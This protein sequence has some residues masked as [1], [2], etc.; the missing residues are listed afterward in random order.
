F[1]LAALAST[2]IHAGAALFAAFAK[3]GR[4]GLTVTLFLIGT[5]ISKATLRKVGVRPMLQGV[6]L[7]IIIATLSLWAIRAHMIGI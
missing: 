6:A 1:C 2:Y 4:S 5:G 3:L 7:W